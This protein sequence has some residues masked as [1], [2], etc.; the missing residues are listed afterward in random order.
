MCAS[1]RGV[2]FACFRA[3][4]FKGRTG[5]GASNSCS[6]RT[7]AVFT[8]A[9]DDAGRCVEAARFEYPGDECH[10]RKRIVRRLDGHLPQAVVR[11][12]IAV[13]AIERPQVIAQHAK[14][15][16]FLHGDRK[17]VAVVL[18][19]QAGKA[20][21]GIE[22]EIDGVELDVRHCMNERCVAFAGGSAST[23]EF[24][25]MHEGRAL[26]STGNGGYF[27]REIGLDR[28]FAGGQ[29]VSDRA[30]CIELGIDE[31]ACKRA[32][33][34]MFERRWHRKECFMAG[35]WTRMCHVPR[36]PSTH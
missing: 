3:L 24:A 7:V 8:Q 20:A 11:R 28:N 34:A 33:G 2:K 13:V 9:S 6:R 4:S 10:A 5:R 14:V 27:D 15:Q 31:R 25:R 19:R 17:P 22:R 36:R 26:R 21:Y 32:S 30:D 35:R 16:G 1:S 18:D 12:K 23:R 29:P